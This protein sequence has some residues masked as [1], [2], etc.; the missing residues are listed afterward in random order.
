LYQPT[1]GGTTKYQIAP[2]GKALYSPYLPAFQAGGP[3]SPYLC[4]AAPNPSTATSCVTPANLAFARTI[5]Y[6][7]D[8]QY[9]QY[10][11]TGGT[12]QPSGQPD[13]RLNYNGHDASHLPNGPFQI[14]N[15]L[16]FPYDAYAA[17]PVHRLFQ[18][19]QQIT[20]ITPANGWGCRA[21]LF[22]WV[23]VTV[24]AG[25]NGKAQPVG[26]IGVG[27]KLYSSWF[28]VRCV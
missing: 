26:Y 11:L 21:D 2:P 22:P 5:Q 14:T 8:D 18:M 27:S 10:L 16:T 19:W 9:Y 6:G 12:G 15:P 13:T 4:P 1:S 23:E 20:A 28:R 3:A 7:L 25:S 24:A 17:S